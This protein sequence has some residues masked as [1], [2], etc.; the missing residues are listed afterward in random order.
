VLSQW[1]GNCVLAVELP[2]PGGFRR[3]LA[4]AGLWERGNEP[5]ISV[6]CGDL[7]DWLSDEEG[8]FFVEFHFLYQTSDVTF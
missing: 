4:T 6:K 8:A 3:F 7:F 1:F 5:S 2:Q